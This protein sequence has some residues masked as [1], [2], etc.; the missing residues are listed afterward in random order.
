MAVTLEN[1]IGMDTFQTYLNNKLTGLPLA[2]GKVYFY[3]QTDGTTPKNVYALSRTPPYTSLVAIPNPNTLNT[4]GTLSDGA[5]GRVI[6]YF[7]P[8]DASGNLELYQ[9]QINDSAGTP[10]DT[11][12]QMPPNASNILPSNTTDEIVNYMNNPQFLLWDHEPVLYG[13]GTAPNNTGR[14]IVTSTVQANTLEQVCDGWY[15][16]RN[17]ST[18]VDNVSQKSFA[19]GQTVV[20]GNPRYYLQYQCTSASGETSK[21][22]MPTPF[23]N[24]NFLQGE[25]VTISFWAIADAARTVSVKWLQNFG[26]LGS[27]QQLSAALATVTLT[28]GWKQYTVSFTV[29]STST[30]VAPS[31]DDYCYPILELDINI[32]CTYGF[33][34]LFLG[35][36]QL[37]NVVFPEKTYA[38]FKAEMP[39]AF[40]VNTGTYNYQAPGS[41][42]SIQDAYWLRVADGLTFGNGTSGATNL[43]LNYYNLYVFFYT[44]YS[45]TV[46]P[47][48]TGRGTDAIADWNAGKTLTINVTG[49][50][51]IGNAGAGATLTTRAAGAS[52]GGENVLKPHTHTFT[53]AGANPDGHVPINASTNT[54]A[55][56]AALTGGANKFI[57]TGSGGGDGIV[58]LAATDSSGSGT[59]TMNPFSFLQLY[60]HL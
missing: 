57:E 45:N 11:L 47:V 51:L 17:A 36:G 31:Q 50:R 40:Q 23:P 33:T 29:P 38:Q 1:C 15:F 26:T 22:L 30:F 49:A 35:Q 53:N 48:S 44:T 20:P 16:Q 37:S 8:F 55:A 28:T 13:S 27:T 12:Y 42:V 5:N 60:V 34:N 4:D 41:V 43:G 7:Y 6:P 2:A 58:N 19:L 46:C 59:D 3:S 24:V 39:P 9:I 25:V 21:R 56:T 14:T 54:F 32:A 10:Q 52:G 18:T